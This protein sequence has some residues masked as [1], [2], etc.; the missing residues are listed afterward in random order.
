[1]TF[2]GTAQFDDDP[3]TPGGLTWRERGRLRTGSHDAEARRSYLIVPSLDGWEVSFEDGRPFHRL[4]LA[5]GRG[6]AE[7]VCGADVYRG[8]YELTGPDAFT[9]TWRVTGP[10]K[11]DLIESDYRRL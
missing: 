5:G 8:A 6:A 4:Q 7:H 2:E 3:R 10:R 1:M 9:V 11:D